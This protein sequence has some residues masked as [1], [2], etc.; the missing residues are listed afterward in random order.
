MV[1]LVQKGMIILIIDPKRLIVEAK[2]PLIKFEKLINSQKIID[3]IK[4]DV[5]KEISLSFN[6]AEK[7]KLVKNGNSS[8]LIIV[9]RKQLSHFIKREFF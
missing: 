6:F 4:K 5:I 7:S 3:N 8:I 9:I 1:M 2:D